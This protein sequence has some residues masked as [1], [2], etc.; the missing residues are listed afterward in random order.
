MNLPARPQAPTLVPLK[1]P[2]ADIPF[3]SNRAERKEMICFNRY[4]RCRRCC[5]SSSFS[6]SLH[7]GPLVRFGMQREIKTNDSCGS[8]ARNFVA[9]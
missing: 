3:V 1:F 8:Y 2:I 4:C 9:N 7:F 6:P 5:S